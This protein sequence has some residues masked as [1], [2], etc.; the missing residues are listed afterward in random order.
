MNEV[1]RRRDSEYGGYDGMGYNMEDY[2]A[3]SCYRRHFIE[4]GGST[5]SRGE[6][7]WKERDRDPSPGSCYENKKE[8]E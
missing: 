5:F 4:P 1:D 2:Q 7:L 3:R 8:K 6:I